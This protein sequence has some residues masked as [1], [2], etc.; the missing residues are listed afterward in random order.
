MIIDKEFFK[1]VDKYQMTL[2]EIGEI[3]NDVVKD[4]VHQG[5]ITITIFGDASVNLG[6]G[7]IN[8]IDDLL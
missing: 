1:D 8:T 6:R 4:N 2:I 3:I 5:G 7:E